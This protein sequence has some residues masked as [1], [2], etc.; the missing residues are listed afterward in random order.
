MSY[1]VLGTQETTQ[2]GINQF[3]GTEEMTQQLGILT[4]LIAPGFGSQYP[5]DDLA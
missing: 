2:Q 3:F 5:N 4:A 1:S